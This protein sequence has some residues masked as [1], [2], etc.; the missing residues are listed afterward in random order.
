MLR[1]RLLAMTGI[2][3]E[4]N[5]PA[6]KGGISDFIAADKPQAGRDLCIQKELG[7]QVDNTVNQTGF[8]QRFANLPFARGFRRER[9]LASTNPA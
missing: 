1:R 7:R 8:D 3:R 6:S 9:P 5:N 4:R 2:F